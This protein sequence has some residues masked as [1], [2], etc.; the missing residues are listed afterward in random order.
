MPD[1]ARWYGR[2]V[3]VAAADALLARDARGLD[4]AIAAA[5]GRMPLDIAQMRVIAASV[6]GGPDQGRWLR[7]ALDIYEGV[8]AEIPGARVRRLLREAGAPV[9]RRRR[10]AAALSGKLA[11]LGVTAREAEVLRLL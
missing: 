5:L 7:E 2:P 1:L 11:D 10:A 6:I 3:L 4:E 9:P 8:S